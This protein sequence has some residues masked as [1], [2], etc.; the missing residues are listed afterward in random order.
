M[1]KEKDLNKKL[2]DYRILFVALII[3]MLFF[4][5]KGFIKTQNIV[6]QQLDNLTMSIT[7]GAEFLTQCDSEQDQ[8][9]MLEMIYNS[10]KDASETIALIAGNSRFMSPYAQK[11]DDLAFHILCMRSEY[12]DEQLNLVI[13]EIQNIAE[14][15]S[16]SE[17]RKTVA[18]DG[19]IYVLDSKGVKEDLD[20]ILDACR[21]L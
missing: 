21:Q 4:W 3:V 8:K 10:A 19:Y 6:G 11:T 2:E 17:I 20:E 13:E 15:I 1:K 9:M 16:D 12:Q 5:G 7:Q 18:R 14:A